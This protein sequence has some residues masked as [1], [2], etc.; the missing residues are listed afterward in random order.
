M[1]QRERVVGIS[2]L[3][4]ALGLATAAIAYVRAHWQPEIFL[5]IDHCPLTP[6]GVWLVGIDG[7]DKWAKQE[8]EHITTRLLALA[9]AMRQHE[10]LALFAIT[11]K[12]EDS[13]AP[14]PLPDFPNGFRLCKPV[15][16]KTV[17]PRVQNE[18]LVR[19]TYEQDFLKPLQAVLPE[20]VAGGT[21]QHSPLLQS[22]EIIMWSPLFGREVPNR[23]LVI[24]SDFLIHTRNLSQLTQSL[25]DPCSVLASDIGK[26]LKARNWQGARVILERLRNPRD[27]A[28]Q[29]AEHI[30]F[31]IRLFYL[32]GAAQVFDGPTLTYISLNDALSCPSTPTPPTRDHARAHRNR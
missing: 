4:V 26:R 28:R 7:T 5:D 32:L 20:L 8:R 27:A 23:T 2:L 10:R 24:F 31:W 19:A 17:D 21:A 11:D 14:W 18:R 30:H 9:E 29:S 1:L 12:P 25:T 15:D 13:A 22:I 16:P 6:E 3:V